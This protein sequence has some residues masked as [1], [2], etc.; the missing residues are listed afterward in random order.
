MERDSDFYE[1]VEQITDKDPRY[2][3]AAYAFVMLALNYTLSKLGE[4]RHVTGKELLEGIREF[5]LAQYGPMTKTVFDYWGVHTTRDF[6]EIVFN[7]VENKLLG[8]TDEDKIEDFS[9]VYDFDEEFVK[10]YPW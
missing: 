8:K 10:K 9:D 4:S 3:V 7:L 2:K 5:A 6:G 1:K